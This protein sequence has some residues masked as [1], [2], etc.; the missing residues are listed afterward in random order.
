MAYHSISKRHAAKVS[1]SYVGHFDAVVFFW[2]FWYCF[3]LNRDSSWRFYI[4]W[5]MVNNDF[6]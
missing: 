6:S 2:V 3:Y 4:I 1:I 5:K